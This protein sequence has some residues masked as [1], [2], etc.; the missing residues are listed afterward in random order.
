MGLYC[1]KVMPF[2]LKNAGATYQR[3][4]NKMFASQIRK[5]MEVYV[6]DMLVKSTKAAQHVV[7]LGAMFD[8][9]RRHHMKL[10]PL[11]CAFGVR[12]GKFPSFMVSS[13]GIDANPEKIKALQDMRSPTNP[14]E[15]S[16]KPEG[17]IK[18]QALADFLAEFSDRPAPSL[19]EEAKAVEWKL[20]VDGASSEA[21]LGAGVML[22]SPEGHKITSAV[23]FQFRA[24]NNEA[25][26]EALIS[27]EIQQ[28]PRAENANAD[29][30]AKLASSKDSDILKVVPIEELQ[31]PTIDEQDEAWTVQTIEN[32][33]T[34]LIQYLADAKLPDDKE[35]A[36]RIKYRVARY[37]LYDGM[38]YRRGF[39]TPLQRCL[40]DEEARGVL[41]EIHEGVCGNHAGGQSLALKVLRQGYYWPTLKKDAFQYARRCDKCQK[42]ASIPRAPPE[43]LT[44]ILSPWPFAKWGIDLIGPLHLTPGGFKFAIVAVDYYTKW[45]EAKALTMTTEAVC[46][47]F[48][49]NNIVCRF[50]VPHSIVSDNGRQF[51]NASTCKFCDSLGIR[52]DFSAPIHPQSNGQVEVVNKILKYTLKKRLDDLKGR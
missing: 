10:N 6:N 13:R 39:S 34:P 27:Y 37:L 35:E 49:W 51:N 20:Y 29:A 33:M 43:S 18:G 25:E 17:A 3:L 50:R 7:H 14:Y 2:G 41:R 21:G 11:K 28:V 40:N 30:L 8:V 45:A 52:K 5:S 48:I 9:L 47:N 42:Y 26:Y 44:S 46:T 19:D 16:H 38:L 4:V 22:I 24:S 1:Y 23:R 12:S 32:W 15:V 36:R 31:R